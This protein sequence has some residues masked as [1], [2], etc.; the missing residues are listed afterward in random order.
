M[1]RITPFKEWI[2]FAK[3]DLDTAKHLYQSM[4]PRPLEIICYH[5]QQSAEKF[6]KAILIINNCDIKRTHDLGMLAELCAQYVDVPDKIYDMCDD[7]TPYGVKI[8]YPQELYLEEHHAC[9]ALEEADYI[10]EWI[11]QL[12]LI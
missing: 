8:R 1:D 2:Q 4:S 7:L 6:L 10:S 5:C 9:L 11:E 12:Q 3:M